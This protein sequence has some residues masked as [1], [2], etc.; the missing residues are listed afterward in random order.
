M[1]KAH[2]L[3]VKRCRF[4]QLHNTSD[5]DVPSCKKLK[6]STLDILLGS[7]ET[8]GKIDMYLQLKPLGRSTNIFD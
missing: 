3:K 4:L 5:G 2:P 6:K 8:N 7:E 1:I